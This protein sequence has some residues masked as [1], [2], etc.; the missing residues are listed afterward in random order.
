M[1]VNLSDFRASGDLVYGSGVVGT[2]Y[3][4]MRLRSDALVAAQSV[5]L[6]QSNTRWHGCK[7]KWSSERLSGKKKGFIG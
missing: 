5:A 1:E 3:V 2:S 7:C 4:G 6:T